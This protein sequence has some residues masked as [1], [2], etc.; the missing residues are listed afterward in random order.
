MNQKIFAVVA[1]DWHLVS[2]QQLFQY[3]SG[4]RAGRRQYDRDGGSEKHNNTWGARAW[5]RATNKK[6]DKVKSP[7]VCSDSRRVQTMDERETLKY[8]MGVAII[9]DLLKM[10]ATELI[11]NQTAH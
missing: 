1:V 9:A 3:H 7:I 6:R 8:T 5:K 11:I 4:I 2:W 10:H